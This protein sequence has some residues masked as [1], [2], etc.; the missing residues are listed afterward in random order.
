MVN[1]VDGS[2]QVETYLVNIRLP[3]GAVFYGVR[4][5]KA[6]LT[7]SANVLIGM[8]IISRGDFTVTNFNGI[9]KFSFRIQSA[10][11]IDFVEESKK[12]QFQHGGKPK[13]KGSRKPSYKGRV[14]KGKK[15]R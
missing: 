8:N 13:P 3:N 6:K 5:T 10:R 2:S 4:V 12:P 1:H 15:N 7:G 9:T 14:K 11:H